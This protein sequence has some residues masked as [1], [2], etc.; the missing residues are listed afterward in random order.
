MQA[1]IFGVRRFGLI[2][3]FILI[4]LALALP[5]FAQ[6]DGENLCRGV[7]QTLTIG[8]SLAGTITSDFPSAFYCFSGERGD[9][10]TITVEVTDGNLA[11]F[12]I[13]TEPIYSEENMTNPLGVGQANRS[14]GTAEVTFEIDSA[15]TYL[16]VVGGLDN[17]GGAFEISLDAEA[18][19]IFDTATEEPE[20]TDED[21]GDN[22][23]P[24]EIIPGETNLCRLDGVETLEYGASVT[25]TLDASNP[26]LWYCF[27]GT[28]GDLVTVEVGTESGDAVMLVALAQP[29]FD[30]TN[31]TVYIADQA[32]SRN[33]SAVIEFSLP[34]DGDY[35]VFLQMSA[36]EDGEY[37]LELS[38]EAGIIYN[39]TNEPLSLLSSNQWM[40]AGAD[41]EAALVTINFAC[42]GQVTVAAMG[43]PE[44]GFYD[45][46]SDGTLTFIY[47]NRLFESISLDD[48]AWTIANDSG[49]EFQLVPVPD[50]TCSDEFS[51]A[52]IQGTWQLGSSDPILFSFMCNGVLILNYQGQTFAQSYTVVDGVISI[53]AGQGQTLD[54]SEIVF[55]ETEMTAKLNGEDVVLRN[56]LAN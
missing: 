33:D 36:G 20:A 28:A 47:G 11:P 38:G 8:D 56:L 15:G 51:Q 46:N 55:S 27:E 13:I 29:F 49:E 3:L 2:S 26:G 30:F 52:L 41:G 31:N 54:F 32:S 9:N 43:A 45:I 6:V 14:G 44:V 23:D 22:S 21:N 12:V 7:T 35:L 10:V 50:T 42:D 34:S 19:S 1:S 53:E 17:N 25:G 18:R 5:T 4:F 40:I 37:Y 48:T 24:T 39:C 16:I